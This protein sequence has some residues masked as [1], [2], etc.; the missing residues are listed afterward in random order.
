MEDTEAGYF[1][2]SP[3]I[4]DFGT[5]N[6]PSSTAPERLVR[7][8]KLMWALLQEHHEL[9]VIPPTEEE[10]IRTLQKVEAH[11]VPIPRKSHGGITY[12]VA[13]GVYPTFNHFETSPNVSN[14]RFDFDLNA[15]IEVFANRDILKNETFIVSKEP[16]QLMDVDVESW[17]KFSARSKIAK[18]TMI[19]QPVLGHSR[20]QKFWPEDW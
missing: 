3:N 4:V 16:F 19:P 6:V 5:L 18:Q 8:S 1:L 10:V 14:C 2:Y 12:L 17:T 7:I 9:P 13:Y 11:M 20:P 15:N